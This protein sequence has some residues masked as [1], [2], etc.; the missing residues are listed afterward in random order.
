[1]VFAKELPMSAFAAPL[2]VLLLAADVS[3]LKRDEVVLF[4]PGFGRLEADG[5]TWSL[6]VQG[7]VFQPEA[8]SIKR[9]LLIA[10]VRKT[11]G[12]ESKSA[13]AQLLDVRLRPFLVDH[14][15]RQVAVRLGSEVLDLGQSGSD[16][17]VAATLSLPESR[18]PKGA[19]NAG[20]RWVS[21]E[22]VLPEKDRRRFFGRVQLIP[23]TGLSVISDI[24]DTI[25]IT[26]VRDRKAMLS[27]T[28]L[29]EFLPVPGMA[30]LYRQMARQGAAFHYVSGSP[31]QLY[32][33]LSQFVQAASYPAGT[34]HLK[35]FRLT[36][37]SGL[38]KLSSQ[39]EY[40]PPIIESLLAA[41]P[42]RRFVLIGD[43]GEKD[44][45]IYAAVAR[46]HPK[47]VAAIYIRNVSDEAVNNPRMLKAFEGLPRDL[48]RLFRESDELKPLLPGLDAK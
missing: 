37:P 42:G 10:G 12:V 38:S 23:P 28:F 11:L 25:K 17:Q 48:W 35:P 39:E 45:E 6:R 14:K 1:V 18:L 32:E 19:A 33:P 27:N 22:T 43:S 9:S 47:Q 20:G 36:D 31:W 8:E 29:R 40:K 5:K 34:F 46:K 3:D 13:Q 16:G 15:K 2:L 26:E 44:P 30:D 41:F 24:D 4:Y 21:F 7:S